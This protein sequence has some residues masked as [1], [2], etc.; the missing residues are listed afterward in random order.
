MKKDIYRLLRIEYPG[1]LYHVMNRC[2]R[3]AFRNRVKDFSKKLN[4]DVS[5]VLKKI[6]E[7]VKR[8]RY[9]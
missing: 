8:G 6:D 5:Q 4:K 1:A 2:R 9:R 7:I 3:G